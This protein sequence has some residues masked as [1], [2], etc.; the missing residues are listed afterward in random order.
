MPR[1]SGIN[2]RAIEKHVKQIAKAYERAA[3]KTPIRVPVEGAAMAGSASSGSGLESEPYLARMLTW[4]AERAAVNP[5]AVQDVTEFAEQ[6]ELPTEDVDILALHLEQRGLVEVV[7][8]YSSK[9]EVHVTD[10]GRVEGRQ[11]RKLQLDR[12]A[13]MRWACDAL[14][15][16]LYDVGHDQ[17][18]VEAAKFMAVPGVYF[19]GDT[20]TAQEIHQALQRLEHHQLIERIDGTVPGTVSITAAGVDFVLSGGSVSDQR[21]QPT[22]GDTYNITDSQGFVAGSQTNVTQNN[23]F[24]IDPSKLHE[25]AAAVKQLAP[26]LGLSEPETAAVIEDAEVLSEETTGEVDDPGR[27]RAA[28]E[29]LTAR[30]EGITNVTPGLLMLIEQGRTALEALGG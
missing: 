15:S 6:E 11:L 19:A 17:A 13:R 7:R 2:K 16:W 22:A 10:E 5:S 4:L 9:T 12:A 8:S 30:L 14:L 20:L 25:F 24:G 18:P 23:T 21:S 29:R 1:N 28:Y 3:Q 26:S 27:I